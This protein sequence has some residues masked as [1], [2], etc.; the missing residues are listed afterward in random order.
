MYACTERLAHIV[1]SF[2]K[3]HNKLFEAA[4]K[5]MPAQTDLLMECAKG[6]LIQ[7]DAAVLASTAGSAFD[8]IGTPR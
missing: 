6:A 3:R 7:I 5:C 2:A 1:A 4:L 8:G